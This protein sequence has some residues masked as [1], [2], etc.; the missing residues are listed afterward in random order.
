MVVHNGIVE[1]TSNEGAAQKV[2]PRFMSDTDTESPPT[3][4][5]LRAEGQG[6][7]RSVSLAL[8]DLKGPGRSVS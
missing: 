2:G 1:N 7:H 3:S 4:L 5:R 8:K 6:F